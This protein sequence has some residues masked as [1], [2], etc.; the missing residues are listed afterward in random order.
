MK[1]KL[2][3][4]IITISLLTPEKLFASGLSSGRSLGMAGAY[5]SVAKGVESPFWNPANLGLSSESK[6]SWRIFS[7]AINAR[8]NSLSLQQYNKYNGKFLTTED[9]Q[10]ILNSI[11]A[12]GLNASLEGDVLAFGVSQGRYAFTISGRGTS[13]LLVPKDP[14]EVLLFG[15][16]IN[17]TILV[18]DTDGE[19]FASMDFGLSH[20]RSFWSK[21]EKELFCGFHA[22]YI[23]GLI[24]QEVTEAEGEVFALETGINGEGD[25]Q[26]RSADGGSGYGLDLGLAFRYSRNWIFGLSFMNMVSQVSWNKETENKVYRMQID[27][28]S[29]DDF[30]ADSMMIEESYTQA[31]GSFTT[32][33]PILL[34]VGVAYQTGRTL[35]SLNLRRG[36]EKGMGV[37]DKLRAS[38]GAEYRFTSWLDVRGGIGLGGEE[39]VTVANGVGF[40]LGKYQLDLGISLQK[41]L[42]PTKSKGICLAISNG[43]SF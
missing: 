41:G 37:S 18:S 35:L 30:D 4:F 13:H 33:V 7:L 31:T 14:I 21:G 42:W 22:R 19:V 1:I 9:K 26:V 11:P 32:R 38:L 36:F 8:N 39:G 43:F 17:D 20:G 29:A 15:N 25:F 23:W 16:E 34:H 5:S 12:E 2:V 40:K 28:L 24:Y 10:N 27:S 3:I 6:R